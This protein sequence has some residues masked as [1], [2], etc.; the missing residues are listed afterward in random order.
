[1]HGGQVRPQPD[2]VLREEAEQPLLVIPNGIDQARDREIDVARL[3]LQER[4]QRRKRDDAA[5]LA[6]RVLV[7]LNELTLEPE[8]R[9]MAAPRPEQRVAIGK[10][11]VA[12][13]RCPSSSRFENVPV[14][15][16]AATAR[17]Q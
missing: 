10:H 15:R 14:P 1:M 4:R 17:P 13:C 3:P 16:H 6:R 8:L 9:R 11:K 7:E 5:L 12:L 2:V